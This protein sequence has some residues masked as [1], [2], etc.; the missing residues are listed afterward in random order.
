MGYGVEEERGNCQ[1]NTLSRE[2]RQGWAQNT[3]NG[4]HLPSAAGSGGGSRVD[5][6]FRAVRLSLVNAF[7]IFIF[8]FIKKSWR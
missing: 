8:S 5:W 6:N 4:T 7:Y 1:I 3:W 2:A